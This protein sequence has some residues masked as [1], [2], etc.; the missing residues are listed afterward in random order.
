[1][2]EIISFPRRMLFTAIR[3]YDAATGL[4]G[5]VAV[6]FAPE[7][8]ARVYQRLHAVSADQMS[9]RIAASDSGSHSSERPISI[10]AK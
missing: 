8:G 6:L 5:V 10:D 9:G 2:T 4:G 7:A 1:M 3:A